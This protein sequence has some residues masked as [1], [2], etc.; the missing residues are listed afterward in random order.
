MTVGP[1]VREGHGRSG[2]TTPTPGHKETRPMASKD[3]RT[4]G[5]NDTRTQGHMKP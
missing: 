4:K 2:F 1:Y 3:T 5:N